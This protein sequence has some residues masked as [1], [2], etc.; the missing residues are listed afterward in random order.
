[1]TTQ[2]PP[3][4]RAVCP[5]DIDDHSTTILETQPL[6]S[7]NVNRGPAAGG[8]AEMDGEVPSRDILKGDVLVGTVAAEQ[9]RNATE[10]EHNLTFIEAVKLYPTAIGWSI[11]CK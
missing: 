9:A 11:F 4:G 1:M 3:F 8:S 5:A 7:R 10:T 2:L 6:L